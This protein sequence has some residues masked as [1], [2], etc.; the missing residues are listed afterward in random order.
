MDG[1]GGILAGS[2]PKTGGA[3]DESRGRPTVFDLSFTVAVCTW[4]RAYQLADTL[5]A[6]VEELVAFP[7][8]RLI[9][10]DNASTDATAEVIN[11]IAGRNPLVTAAH[12][13]KRGA[14]HAIARAISLAS[15][16]FLVFVDDDAMPRPGCFAT[17]LR[18][19]LS[20]PMLGYVSASIEGVWDQERPGWMGARA[21]REIPVMSWRPG[22]TLCDYPRYPPSVTVALR[23]APCLRLFC[24]EERQFIE[25]GWGGGGANGLST[26][27]G[28]DHDL[29]EIFKRNG[30]KVAA[31][32]DAWVRHRVVTEKLSPSWLVGKFASEG[33]LRVRFARIAGYPVVSR[34]TLPIF[35]A[36]PVLTALLPLARLLPARRRV[37]IEA[38]FAK[39]VGAWSEGLFGIRGVRFQYDL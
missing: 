21:L 7:N 29:A 24:T 31:L 26:V 20:D 6:I 39:S 25:L 30:F 14:Y 34:H 17:L 32:G 3:E 15:G 9:V 38:Y 10:V 2:V 36:L 23:M 8:A 27:G 22:Q 4:N 16:E 19:M 12:E 37:L 28:D 13:A 1:R 11:E 18:A 33:R 5:S 35:L